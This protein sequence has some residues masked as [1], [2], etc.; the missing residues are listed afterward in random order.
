MNTHINNIT[1]KANSTLAVLKRNVR[2]PSKGFQIAFFGILCKIQLIYIFL[3]SYLFKKYFLILQAMDLDDIVATMMSMGFEF[4]DCQD[5]IQNG[6][7]TVQAG[8]EW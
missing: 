5:A 7:L 3:K 6:K 1:N 4:Q 2:V 8:I